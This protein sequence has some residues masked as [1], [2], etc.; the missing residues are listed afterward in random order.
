ML[1]MV[2]ATLEE[3]LEKERPVLFSSYNPFPS[4]PGTKDASLHSSAL[5]E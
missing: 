5:F 2:N 4:W 1:I 3:K